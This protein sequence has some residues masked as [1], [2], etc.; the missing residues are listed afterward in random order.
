M[1]SE[2]A[3]ITKAVFEGLGQ[4]TKVI[5]ESVDVAS[6]VDEVKKTLSD[7]FTLAVVAVVFLILL[8]A[9]MAVAMSVTAAAT[10]RTHE[11]VCVKKDVKS[12][13]SSS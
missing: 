12:L 9:G 7:F 2:G 8:V 10:W 5:A 4:V 3:N 1:S 11:C 6:L 13:L